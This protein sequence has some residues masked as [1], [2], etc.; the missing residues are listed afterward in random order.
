LKKTYPNAKCAL[1]HT[2]PLELLV[3]TILSA[4]CTDVRV[5]QRYKNAFKKYKTAADWRTRLSSN[6]TDI[7]TTGFY[8][9]KAANI[10][11]AC[12]KLI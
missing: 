10:Q 7:K 5:E 9:N 11:K 1:N 3:A 2:N 8:H 12:K 4:Q 6:R